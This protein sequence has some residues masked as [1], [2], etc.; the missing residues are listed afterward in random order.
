MKY[1]IKEGFN[2]VG[3]IVENDN[4]VFLPSDFA[5]ANNNNHKF[6][7]LLNMIAQLVSTNE[8]A[9]LNQVDKELDKSATIKP[10]ESGDI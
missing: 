7:D 1:V 8:Y 5:Q 10:I 2:K 6:L 4:G 9:E 3:T